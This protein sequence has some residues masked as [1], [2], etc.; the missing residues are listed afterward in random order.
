MSR[1]PPPP[2]S[3][4]PSNAWMATFSDLLMLMLTFFVL[5]LTM[6][7]LDNRKVKSLTRDGIHMDPNSDKDSAVKFDDVELSH[8]SNTISAMQAL[9]HDPTDMALQGEVKTKME[10]LLKVSGI[11]ASAWVEVRPNGVLVNIDG[12]LAF[13]PGSNKLTPE[14][15]KFLKN[16]AA[17][18][19][20]DEINVAVDAWVKGEGDFEQQELAWELAI[21][22]AE[23]VTKRLFRAGLANDR[24]RMMGYGFEGGAQEAR[25]VRQPE[26]VRV[27]AIVGKAGAEF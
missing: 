13:E 25:F 8:V 20:D 19:K 17:V 6:S 9:S 26:L 2:A 18:V 24:A 3:G 5:L 1:R 11:H 4:G 16:F 15:D 27:R 23:T 14:A 22:R 12:G 10:D 21:R 7:S